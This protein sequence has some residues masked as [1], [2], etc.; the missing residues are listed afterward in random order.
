MRNE[1][2][3]I[4]VSYMKKG[5]NILILIPYFGGKIRGVPEGFI[6]VR[7]FSDISSSPIL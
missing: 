7:F 2:N 6:V 4:I 5:I 1:T 3:Q